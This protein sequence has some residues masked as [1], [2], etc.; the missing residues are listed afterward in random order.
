MCKWRTHDRAGFYYT[1]GIQHGVTFLPVD[2]RLVSTDWSVDP[3]PAHANPVT[4]AGGT[5]EE[6]DATAKGKTRNDT[7]GVVLLGAAGEVNGSRSL[8]VMLE[9]ADGG[10]T[11]PATSPPKKPTSE[12]ALDRAPYAVA[13]LRMTGIK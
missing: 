13:I 8:D 9:G 10:K 2:S 11:T 7:T 1:M 6:G 4:L 3:R 5:G 12:E